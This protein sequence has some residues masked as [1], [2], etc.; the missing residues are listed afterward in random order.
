MKQKWNIRNPLPRLKNQA[1]FHLYR[2]KTTCPGICACEARC[3]PVWASPAQ[4]GKVPVERKMDFWRK[5]PF[6]FHRKS[7]AAYGSA[8]SCAIAVPSG[9]R[10]RK[11]LPCL[12][13]SCS[14][15]LKTAV[16]YVER[17]RY[18]AVVVLSLFPLINLPAFRGFKQPGGIPNE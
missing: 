5:G 6:V 11:P 13:K 16:L 9:T 7:G 18:R 17:K 12:G 1:L 15:S 10:A 14:T 4:N 2:Q 3:R 8:L